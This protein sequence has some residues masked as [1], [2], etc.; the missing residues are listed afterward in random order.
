MTPGGLPTHV[1]VRRRVAYRS[2]SSHGRPA[3]DGEWAGSML[4]PAG[5]VLVVRGV[6]ETKPGCLFAEDES[7]VAPWF[8]SRI[9]PSGWEEPW[10]AVFHFAFPFPVVYDFVVLIA[11]TDKVIE[12]GYPAFGPVNHVVRLGIFDLAIT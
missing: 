9:Q 12:D 8:A 3:S 2:G 6:C 1:V 11:E 4:L 5:A 10:N 7:V